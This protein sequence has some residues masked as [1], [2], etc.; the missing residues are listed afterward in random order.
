MPLNVNVN[1]NVNINVNIKLELRLFEFA[2]EADH[3]NASDVPT[4][5]DLSASSW[6][7]ELS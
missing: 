3:Q 1:A 5:A 2:M 7:S 6:C 4:F